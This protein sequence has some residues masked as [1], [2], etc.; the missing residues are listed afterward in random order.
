MPRGSRK[1]SME[2]SRSPTKLNREESNGDEYGGIF[3]ESASSQ[4]V[5]TYEVMN[6]M[7]SLTI[8]S[9]KVKI[10]LWMA[11]YLT[12]LVLRRK[13]RHFNNIFSSLIGIIDQILCQII[14]MK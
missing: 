4:H 11:F 1:R 8:Y 9:W 14:E 2:D 5:L 12:K 3:P 10:P 7:M 6:L 13:H